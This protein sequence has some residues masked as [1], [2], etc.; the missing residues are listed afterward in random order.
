MCSA[1]TYLGAQFRRQMIMVLVLRGSIKPDRRVQWIRTE[2]TGPVPTLE[3]EAACHE[4]SYEYECHGDKGLALNWQ[5]KLTTARPRGSTSTRTSIPRATATH[6]RTVSR[7][8]MVLAVGQLVLITLLMSVVA[9]HQA[10]SGSQ[11]AM[12]TTWASA[13]R[14]PGCSM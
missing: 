6:Y 11:M 13:S 7:M 14:R 8:V 5:Y 2:T 1:V 4:Y 9:V 12:M 3:A 10:I